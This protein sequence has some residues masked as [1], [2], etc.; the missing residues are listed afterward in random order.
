MASCGGTGGTGWRKWSVTA[1][2][3]ISTL[4][5]PSACRRTKRGHC[6]GR[7][8]EDVVIS[9][10]TCDDWEGGVEQMVKAFLD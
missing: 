1:L 9:S 2:V 5:D 7:K 4:I 6:L 8:S 3:A 10:V